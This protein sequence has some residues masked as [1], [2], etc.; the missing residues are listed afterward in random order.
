[1]G[2]ICRVGWNL[3][4]VLATVMCVGMWGCTDV[5]FHWYE[6]RSKASVIGFIDDSLA[7][8]GDYRCWAEYVD[9][10]NGSYEEHYDCGHER[11]CVYNYRVQEDGPRWCDSLST[12][13]E[14]NAFGGQM[15]DSIIWG[16]ELPKSIKLWK[17]GETQHEIKL[18][19]TFDNC[20]DEFGIASAK[21]WFDGKF[22]VRGEKSLTAGNDSCQ[23]AVL[24]TVGRTL[25]Y[26]RLD[27][28][29][30]W[31]EKCD[32]VRAWDDDVY[33]L[34]KNIEGM[35]LSLWIDNV[36]SDSIYVKDV[37]F[38]DLGTVKLSS[39]S[40]Y[41]DLVYWGYLFSLKFDEKKFD[42]DLNVRPMSFPN[43]G[44]FVDDKKGFISYD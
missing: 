3:F 30:K 2:G 35:K 22:I 5:D 26:K 17:V 24:D 12:K 25:V 11:L 36:L 40:F 18:K 1:M 8:V 39:L 33:C 7:I 14:E 16:G 9:G 27:E 42:F 20:S 31:I 44:S 37:A 19:K 21:Q 38:W 29:L 6:H 15:A 32:D 28:N 41:G 43:F 23:Y 10:W 4:A 34:E 13:S